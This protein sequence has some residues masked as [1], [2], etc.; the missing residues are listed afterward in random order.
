MAARLGGA[1]VKEVR[2]WG[3]IVGVELAADT[4]YTAADVCAQVLEAGM[5]TVPAGPKVVRLVPPLVVSESQIDEAVTMLEA[6]I[7]KLNSAQTS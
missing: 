3:L 6:A 7:T 5:L 2:G 1:V 4:T